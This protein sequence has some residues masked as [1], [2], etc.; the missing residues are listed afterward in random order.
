MF[1]LLCCL[2]LRIHLPV[3]SLARTKLS[4][5]LSEKNRHLILKWYISQTFSQYPAKGQTLNPISPLLE[6]NIVMLNNK[7]ASDTLQ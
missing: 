2:V 6:N 3:E 7:A 5:S 1:Y 4:T